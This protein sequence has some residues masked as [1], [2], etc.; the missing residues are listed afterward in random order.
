[1][2]K[3]L[4]VCIILSSCLLLFSTSYASVRVKGYFKK[5]GTYVSPYYRSNPDGIKSNN[6][7]YPGNTNPY[8]GKVAPGT[9][10]VYVAPNNNTPD[11]DIGGSQNNTTE[12][13]DG[14]SLPKYL[15][16]KNSISPDLIN[17][18]N[19]NDVANAQA[20]PQ[21]VSE[22]QKKIYSSEPTAE[23]K[24]NTDIKSETTLKANNQQP[25]ENNENKSVEMFGGLGVISVIIFMI[26]KRR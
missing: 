7:S 3:I 10:P 25:L 9:P 4:L 8:T 13:E 24:T 14:S 11:Y 15:R 21:A 12:N 5:N 22:L 6:W 17:K 20:D 26:M 23:P 19:T 16:P 18:A 1:M 2:K